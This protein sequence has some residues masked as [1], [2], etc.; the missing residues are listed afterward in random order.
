MDSAKSEEGIRKFTARNRES[1]DEETIA[2]GYDD[3][4]SAADSEPEE[5]A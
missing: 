2:D 4:Q 5:S 3:H 1:A